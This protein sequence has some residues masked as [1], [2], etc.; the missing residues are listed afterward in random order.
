MSAARKLR[1]SIMNTNTAH[2]LGANLRSC[3]LTAHR[4][5]LTAQRSPL[6]RLLGS[7]PA[8]TAPARLARHQPE[9]LREG[10]AHAARVS[11]ERSAADSARCVSARPLATRLRRAARTRLAVV[12][13]EALKRV[14]VRLVAASAFA[15]GARH[16]AF[17]GAL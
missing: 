16:T 2:A 11:G 8:S 9:A 13:L 6:S 17:V 1:P 7:Q 4:S 5:A 12:A 14:A 3:A 10:G 15:A